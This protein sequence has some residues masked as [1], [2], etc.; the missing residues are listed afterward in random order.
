[1]TLVVASKEDGCAWMVADV[2]LTGGNIG[3]RDRVYMPKVEAAHNSSFL[4]FAGDYHHGQRI[5]RAASSLP[6]GEITLDFLTQSHRDVP[7]VDLAYGYWSS[8]GARLFRIA[9]GLTEEVETLHLG[10]ETAFAEFQALR[11]SN[12]P[13]HA[14]NA[15]DLFMSGAL[16]PDVM[17]DGLSTA[18]L[19]MMRLCLASG[20]RGVSG[21]V[22]PFLLTANGAHLCPYAYSATDPITDYLRP[23]M[24]I[25]HGT[26]EAGGF[27][28]SFTGLRD[29]DGMIVY[30]LQGSVGYIYLRTKEGYDVRELRGG[31]ATF[32]EQVRE[33][34]GRDVDL[35]FGD[36]PIGLPQSVSYWYDQAGR[37]RIAVAK[38][39][40]ALSFAWVQ[41]TDQSF[42]TDGTITMGEDLDKTTDRDQPMRLEATLALDRLTTSIVL[43]MEGR[44][45]G[46]IILDARGLQDL[47][48]TLTHIRAGMEPP[49]ALE[50]ASGTKL[51]SVIDPVWRARIPPHPSIP[52]PLL[53]LRHP[54]FGWLSF[55]FP[56]VE[57]NSLG[58]WLVANSRKPAQ[59]NDRDPNE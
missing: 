20:R 40:R 4:G 5:I 12:E 2:A 10:D 55:V 8:N 26:S 47:I 43:T 27:G 14:P 22:V 29:D 45:L 59:S 57:A 51:P 53:V 34:L 56:D 13:D 18:I 1:M 36:N 50:I 15:I 54:G 24:A 46:H 44:P 11:L 19:S 39:V 30:F 7:S 23:G 3:H 37:P 21:W 32:R 33:Q 49:V 6:Q 17:P 35:W 52:G 42:A 41:S 25:P 16:D 38:H 58:Q 48:T 28:L 9:R 31:P